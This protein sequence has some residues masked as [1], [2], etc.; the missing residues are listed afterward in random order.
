MRLITYTIPANVNGT[1][2]VADDATVE[3]VRQ[4]VRDDCPKYVQVKAG[5]NFDPDDF[6]I[7]EDESV[8]EE[9]A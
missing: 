6:D 4:A 5:E 8:P 2:E 7:L 9:T 3:D 1:V